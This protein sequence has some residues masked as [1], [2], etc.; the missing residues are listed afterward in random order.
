MN[1]S[2]TS[3][4]QARLRARRCPT[5]GRN[6]TEDEPAEAGSQEQDFTVRDQRIASA[7][8]R[9]QRRRR[10]DIARRRRA[11]KLRSPRI[12]E[13]VDVQPVAEA[14]AMFEA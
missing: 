4:S 14:E 12:A 10:E 3:G 8:A 13:E 7:T 6:S 11:E 5:G 2:A 1:R 9:P